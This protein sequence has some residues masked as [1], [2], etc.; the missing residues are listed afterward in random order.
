LAV[1]HVFDIGL[2]VVDGVDAVFGAFWF[3]DYGLWLTDF[4]L[5]RKSGGAVKHHS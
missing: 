1:I 3:M 4:G 5:K 2:R